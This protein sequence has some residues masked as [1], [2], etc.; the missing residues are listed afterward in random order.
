M[1]TRTAISADDFD[2]DG[3]WT[4]CWNCGG[5][6]A[7]SSCPTEYACMDPEGGCDLCKRRCDICKGKGGWLTNEPEP[8]A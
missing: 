7:V 3:P 8:N 4:D 5:E 1:T 2:I 6:G